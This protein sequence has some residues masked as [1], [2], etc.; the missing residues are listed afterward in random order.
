MMG[1]PS[2]VRWSGPAS[3]LGAVLLVVQIALSST[4]G[5]AQGTSNPYEIYNLLLFVVYNLLLDTALLLLAVGLVG[6]Y[7]RQA[8]RSGQLGRIGSFLALIAA[9]SLIVGAFAAIMVG[10]WPRVY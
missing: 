10:L 3:I 1:S 9:A 8:G 4:L 5:P 6:L 2:L 7:A